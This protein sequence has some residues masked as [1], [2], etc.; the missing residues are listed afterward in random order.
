MLVFL[1][2]ALVAQPALAL[3]STRTAFSQ[4]L[5]PFQFFDFAY[6]HAY[7]SMRSFGSREIT[8]QWIV[9]LVATQLLVILRNSGTVHGWAAR[10]GRRG[11]SALLTMALAHYGT[12]YL[13]WH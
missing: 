3:A 9:T 11:A 4:F 5:F 6:L 8:P 7:F 10:I 1:G 12:T 2:L 13:L